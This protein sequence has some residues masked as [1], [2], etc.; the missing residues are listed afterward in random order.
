MPMKAVSNIR[1]LIALW[2]SRLAF[3]AAVGVPVDRVHKWA[4][5]NAIPAKYH[6]AV[7]RSAVGL[8]LD[9]SAELLVRLHAEGDVTEGNAA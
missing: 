9:V 2:P 6:L 1:A 7:L 8:D 3:A 5:S 4:A